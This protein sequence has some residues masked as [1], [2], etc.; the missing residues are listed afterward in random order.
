MGKYVTYRDVAKVIDPDAFFEPD[1][2]TPTER[3][4]WHS[5]STFRQQDAIAK[6][7]KIRK[8][9]DEK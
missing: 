4:R 5:S 3:Q 7:R 1:D 9:M 2:L 6:A 8:L